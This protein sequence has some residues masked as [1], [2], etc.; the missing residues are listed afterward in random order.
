MTLVRLESREG[1]AAH[2]NGK[3]V[4]VWLSRDAASSAKHV[5]VLTV[6]LHALH[7]LWKSK[8]EI[9]PLR[10]WKLLVLT[11]N[12]RICIRWWGR[13]KALIS[14]SF[15]EQGG[16]VPNFYPG[17]YTLNSLCMY[18]IGVWELYSF[19]HRACRSRWVCPR[20]GTCTWGAVLYYYISR[21]FFDA[22]HVHRIGV[23]VR[24]PCLFAHQTRW[25]HLLRFHTG[26]T[27]VYA[28]VG[29][30]ASTI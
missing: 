24:G 22:L 30:C 19:V 4:C 25:R 28:C 7:P 12:T 27:H 23:C 14:T 17:H 29:D 1:W 21:V 16:V 8:S 18:R 20:V 11:T 9:S 10:I 2:Y 6:C 3:D 13:P 15:F 5:W 26:R